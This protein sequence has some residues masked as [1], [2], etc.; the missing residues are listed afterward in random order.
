MTDATVD[1]VHRQYHP[2]AL[3]FP[4]MQ[5]AE[6]DALKRDIAEYGQRDP[7]WLH[8]DGRIIDGRNRH[9]ACIELGIAPHFRTWNG[10]GSLVAFVVSL[11]LHRRHLDAGQ[12]AMIGLKVK[13]AIAAEIAAA[14]PQKGRSAAER[15]WYGPEANEEGLIIFDQTHSPGASECRDA[16][17]ES[18][19]I[20]SVSKTTMIYAQAVAERAPELAERVR[21]G[22]MKLNAAYREMKRQVAQVAPPLPNDKYRIIYADPPWSYGNTMPPGTTQPDDYYSLMTTP[23]ICAL[24]VRAMVESDAVLFLWTTSPHLPEAFDVIKAWGFEYK[25]SFVWDKVKHNMGHYN[26]V[27][28]EFLLVCTRGSCT[29]DVPRLFDS[30]QSIE[31]TEH[32]VK[33]EAFRE[34]IDTIY[35]YGKRVELFA[36]RPA[37]GW[38]TWGNESGN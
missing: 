1:E 21:A 15:Q 26:S 22:D 5:G 12:R 29:P 19:E 17:A 16:L 27:R 10:D 20:V 34:I 9:R 11:N 35:P 14:L 23:D 18:G 38:E 37:D 6:F 4:L 36:R 30:V 8:E 28:H 2:A 33:P 7:I 3:L 32:S 25:T 13:E 24:P 31:R